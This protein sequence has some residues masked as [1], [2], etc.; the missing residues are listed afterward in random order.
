MASQGNPTVESANEATGVEP[1]NASPNEPQIPQQPKSRA[2]DIPSPLKSLP[3]GCE[4]IVFP[5]S[6]DPTADTH[7]NVASLPDSRKFEDLVKAK[8][9]PA[10][11][12]RAVVMETAAWQDKYADVLDKVRQAA[13]EG[14]VKFY[15]LQTG[16]NKAEGYVVGLDVEG[17]RLLGVRI[18]GLE[19]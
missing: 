6:L 15:R 11:P 4:L 3:D 19:G 9:R 12:A 18:I 1:L 8:V 5:L 14:Q 10:G 16:K 17:E 2:D 7:Q 13:D